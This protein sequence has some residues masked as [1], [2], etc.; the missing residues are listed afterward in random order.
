MIKLS[1][2]AKRRH[3]GPARVF[4]CEEDAKVALRENISDA[5]EKVSS[6]HAMVCESV[7][8]KR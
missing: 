3:S 7:P 8:W 6:I 4:E 5:H 2:Y 1:G